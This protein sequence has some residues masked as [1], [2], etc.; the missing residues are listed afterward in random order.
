MRICSLARQP[1]ADR[2]DE[3]FYI[4]AAADAETVV[5]HLESFFEDKRFHDEL[6]QAAAQ[7]ASRMIVYLR[8][9]DAEGREK[10]YAELGELAE[11]VRRVVEDDG[12]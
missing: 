1:P 10:I 3:S 6:K 2:D 9:V 8:R 7:E 12:E 5:K 11:M 4:K